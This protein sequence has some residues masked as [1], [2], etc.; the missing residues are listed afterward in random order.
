[1]H[2]LGPTGSKKFLEASDDTPI[3][4]IISKSVIKANPGLYKVKT[5]G[6]AKARIREKLKAGEKTADLESSLLDFFKNKE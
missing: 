2:N 6:E 4:K 3:H 5:V 1:M